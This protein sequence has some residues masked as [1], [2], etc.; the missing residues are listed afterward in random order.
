MEC[1][2]YSFL[3]LLLDGSTN[4]ESIHVDSIVTADIEA[5]IA[6]TK[7]SAKKLADQY[8]KWQ[9]QYESVWTTHTHVQ[10]SLTSY[11]NFNFS[12]PNYSN[13]N[14]KAAIVATAFFD[15]L[16]SFDI[17]VRIDVALVTGQN[18]T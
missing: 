18:L 9:K 8:I 11:M 7:P 5:S 4:W 13:F 3:P 10:Q 15:I 2:S 6:S 12:G 16:P 14:W 17:Q 1:T